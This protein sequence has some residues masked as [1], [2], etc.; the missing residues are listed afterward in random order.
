MEEGRSY[1]KRCAQADSEDAQ[2][3]CLYDLDI[4]FDPVTHAF[5]E[6][7]LY[8]ELMEAD[9]HAIVGLFSLISPWHRAFGLG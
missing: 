7:Y 8:E 5:N 6:V 4:V 3:T 9:L 2:I 1:S